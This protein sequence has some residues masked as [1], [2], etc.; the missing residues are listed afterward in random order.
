MTEHVV[1]IL[2][3]ERRKLEKLDKK[4]ELVQSGIELLQ[5]TQVIF[6]YLEKYDKKL[7]K[8]LVVMIRYLMRESV[9]N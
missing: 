6:I 1:G 3:E 5:Q 2:S 8:I 7:C 9:F 4:A